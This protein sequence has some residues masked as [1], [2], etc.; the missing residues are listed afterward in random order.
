MV[1]SQGIAL[2]RNHYYQIMSRSCFFL[3]MACAI[4]ASCVHQKQRPSPSSFVPQSVRTELNGSHLY[5]IWEK[6]AKLNLAG[7]NVYI[8]QNPGGPPSKYNQSLIKNNF[9]PLVNLP[10]QQKFYFTVTAM[11]ANLDIESEKSQEVE[12]IPS[13]I[14]AAP[15]IVAREE[16]LI[17]RWKSGLSEDGKRI[18]IKPGPKQESNELENDDSPKDSIEIKDQG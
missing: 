16:T 3:I 13:Q 18:I 9:L 6:D 2:P 17:I 14:L 11:T 5:L 7:W 4:F 1:A 12:V 15:E 8:S 10:L